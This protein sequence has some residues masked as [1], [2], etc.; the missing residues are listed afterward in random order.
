M[1]ECLCVLLAL[2]EAGGG[3][4]VERSR[5]ERVEQARRVSTSVVTPPLRPA[6]VW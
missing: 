3:L 6:T 2:V 4:I 5:A 1:S